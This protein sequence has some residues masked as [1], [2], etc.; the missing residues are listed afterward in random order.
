VSRRSR[1]TPE[2]ME[3][4]YRREHAERVEAHRNAV[5]TRGQLLDIIDA[6]MHER[7]GNVGDHME[8]DMALLQ[9][10][11]DAVDASE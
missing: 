10:F 3:L 7:G 11:R 5:V 6:V 4:R 1:E 8:A 2:E 9:A